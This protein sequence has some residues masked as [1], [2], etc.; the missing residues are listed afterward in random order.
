VAAEHVFAQGR[1]PLGYPVL[2]RTRGILCQNRVAERAESVCRKA[3]G[4]RIARGKE[5]TDGSVSDLNIS[6]MADGCS[7]AVLSEKTTFMSIIL[8]A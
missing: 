7:G 3:F 8:S 1:V 6:L 4:R 5:I 2:K